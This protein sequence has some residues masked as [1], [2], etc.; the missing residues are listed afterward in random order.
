MSNIKLNLIRDHKHNNTRLSQLLVEKLLKQDMLCK[1]LRTEKHLQTIKNESPYISFFDKHA[2][3]I[4]I[5]D[6]NHITRFLKELPIPKHNTRII[7][8]SMME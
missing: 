8:N 4:K 3:E 5:Y 7:Y 1:V 2:N 6:F